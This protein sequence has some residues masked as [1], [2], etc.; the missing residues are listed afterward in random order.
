AFNSLQ[1]R[2]AEEYARLQEEIQLAQ[3]VQQQLFPPVKLDGGQW[4]IA[5][6]GEQ[7]KVDAHLFQMAER[8]EGHIVL[9]AGA[10]RGNAP[11]AALVMSSLL[12]LIRA[13]ASHMASAE[14]LMHYMNRQL[15]DVLARTMELHI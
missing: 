5:G 13:Q 15:A 7:V 4:H 14:S 10:I 9:A 6:S 12:M 8:Q 1:H 3:H 2:F 11:S